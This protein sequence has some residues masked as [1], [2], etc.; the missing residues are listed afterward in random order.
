M[1]SERDNEKVASL[2]KKLDEN[3]RAEVNLMPIIL[4][5]AEN[6]ATLGEIADTMRNV[7]GEFTG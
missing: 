5:S 2:L 3:A 4:E 1:K 7:F 6:Y